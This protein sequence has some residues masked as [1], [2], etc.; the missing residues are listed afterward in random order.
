MW[1]NI[2]KIKNISFNKCGF[3]LKLISPGEQ[4]NTSL[5]NDG[6][7]ENDRKIFY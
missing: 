3:N 5:D 2:V 6:D 4:E 1:K 7:E